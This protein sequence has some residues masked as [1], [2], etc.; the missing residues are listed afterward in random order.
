MIPKSC[1]LFGQDHAQSQEVM[2][3]KVADFSDKMMLKI[4]ELG[5]RSIQ[6]D[7]IAL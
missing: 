1:R 6:P 3:L 7:S 2:I 5:A 4:K